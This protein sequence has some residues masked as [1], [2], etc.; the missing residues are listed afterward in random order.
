VN[1][2]DITQKTKENNKKRTGSERGERCYNYNLLSCV[3]SPTRINEHR[4]KEKNNRGEN[5]SLKYNL[6]SCVFSPT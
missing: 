5:E 2:P 4:P 3:I 1:L 6:L